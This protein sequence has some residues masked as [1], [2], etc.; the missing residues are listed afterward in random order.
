M[1]RRRFPIKTETVSDSETFIGTYESSFSISVGFKLHFVDNWFGDFVVVF[2]SKVVDRHHLTR[3]S[4]V[5][6]GLY[7]RQL[8]IY[9]KVIDLNRHSRD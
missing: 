1:W 6:I 4:F 9:S 3:A 5:G 8:L 2:L 7:L